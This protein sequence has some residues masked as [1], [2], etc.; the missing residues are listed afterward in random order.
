V[1]KYVFLSFHVT[2]KDISIYVFSSL[3]LSHLPKTGPGD[4][5]VIISDN[6]LM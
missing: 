3:A 1:A 2:F 6:Y 5:N 4:V